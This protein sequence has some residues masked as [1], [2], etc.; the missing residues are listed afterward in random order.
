MRVRAAIVGLWCLLAA[1]FTVSC[2]HMP[3]TDD[4]MKP[5]DA[6]F[7]SQELS[8]CGQRG[9]HIGCPN[10]YSDLNIH[11]FYAG[12]LF[13]KSDRCGY[14][15]SITFEE[16]GWRT[17]THEE[18]FENK[19]EDETF[20]DFEIVQTPD[21][22]DAP[23][24]GRWVVATP[25]EGLSAIAQIRRQTFIGIAGIQ[26]KEGYAG[27]EYIYFPYQFGKGEFLV[28]G[29]GFD[30]VYPY[31]HSQGNVKFNLGLLEKPCL[32][33]FGFFRDDKERKEREFSLSVSFFSDDY[34]KLPDPIVSLDS[35]D[36]WYSIDYVGPIAATNYDGT[37]NWKDNSFGFPGMRG[38][39]HFIRAITGI[40]RY[41]LLGINNGEIVWRPLTF[42]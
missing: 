42:P 26:I 39:T 25:N 15:R 12:N 23:L 31:D 10:F 24:R 17:F 2:H 29:C 21:N 4:F 6:G 38:K 35:G 7:Y 20:C 34:V 19:P 30:E 18:L 37:Y 13:I 9:F 5:K 8:A 40:G 32:Y 28:T 1:I 33:K 11:L 22:W 41:N 27:G 16:L 36:M 3:P 14:E